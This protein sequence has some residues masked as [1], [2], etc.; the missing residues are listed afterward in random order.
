MRAV[1]L[2]SLV[3]P[4]QQHSETIGQLPYFHVT[5]AQFKLLSLYYKPIPANEKPYDLFILCIGFARVL[6]Y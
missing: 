1:D 6:S 5:T 3:I 2:N 4:K